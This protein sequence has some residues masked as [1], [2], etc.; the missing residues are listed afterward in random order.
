ML[1]ESY[2]YNCGVLFVNYLILINVCVKEHSKNRILLVFVT[3]TSNYLIL[4]VGKMTQDWSI[5]TMFGDFNFQ[6]FIYIARFVSD[7]NIA[8]QYSRPHLCKSLRHLG[9][10]S[11]VSSITTSWNRISHKASL[12]FRTRCFNS[13]KYV[14]QLWRQNGQL[15]ICE[16]NIFMTQSSQIWLLHLDVPVGFKLPETQIRLKAFS[17]STSKQIGHIFS[18][19]VWFVRKAHIYQLV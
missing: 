19:S 12:N 10:Y 4:C 18:S 5:K 2:T 16:K 7:A 17:L 13:V 9:M 11:F 8:R 3:Y 15:Y 14:S 1:Q 6:W